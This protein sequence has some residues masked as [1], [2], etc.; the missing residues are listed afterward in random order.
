MEQKR[1]HLQQKMQWQDNP[2]THDYPIQ[3]C[4]ADMRRNCIRNFT[5][6]LKCFILERKFGDSLDDNRT[7]GISPD[8]GNHIKPPEVLREG[9]FD[10]KIAITR[11]SIL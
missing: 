5:D 6:N 2:R 11:K 4:R 10:D 8:G 1:I 7:Q 3:P 9:Q